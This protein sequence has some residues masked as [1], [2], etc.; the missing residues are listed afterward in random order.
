[1][2]DIAV[3]GEIAIDGVMSDHQHYRYDRSGI[4]FFVNKR[5]IKNHHLGSALIKGYANVIPQDRYPI[6]A[7]NMMVPAHEVD[8]NIH[9]R[10][11]EVKFLHPRKVEQALQQAV[12]AA[13]EINLSQQLKKDITF[14]SSQDFRSFNFDTNN[15]NTTFSQ[16]IPINLRSTQYYS[17]V[18]AAPQNN[19]LP[20][21]E[22]QIPVETFQPTL[23][24]IP[25]DAYTPHNTYRL[26]GQ[27]N[28]TYLLVEKEDGLF[29]VDQHA[30]HERILYELFSER[31]NEVATVQ[32]L[33]P[34]TITLSPDDIELITPHL[35]IFTSNGI[36]IEQYAHD[37]L[38]IQSLPV[39]LK[40][41]S[42]NDLLKEV[43][44]WII[45]YKSLNAQEFK[46]TINNKLHAQMACKAAVKAGDILT[47]EKMEQLL[48]DLEKTANRFS[49][50]HGR[51]TGWLISLNDIEKKFRRRL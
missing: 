24:D 27:Y 7:I 32:L 25:T 15:F 44:G 46:K 51:P 9:P 12:K 39:H 23:A 45:E 31:F 14:R 30:A 22:I 26:I 34:Q 1:M 36:I 10:K 19:P 8:I 20:L 13:L 37:Q 5:W 40:E 38:I 3:D 28:A 35:D 2:L 21:D 11:E 42:L 18:T 29:L 47:Q 4:Y 17:P 16:P 6:A 43:I 50:P 33:F 41:H 49:C 48:H